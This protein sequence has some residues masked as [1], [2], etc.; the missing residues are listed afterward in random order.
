ML[1]SLTTQSA[2]FY[3]KN[4]LAHLY[5]NQNV[6]PVFRGWSIVS[7]H[8]EVMYF[9][10][11]DSLLAA[12]NARFLHIA[13]K[14]VEYLYRIVFLGQ[15]CAN[16][17]TFDFLSSIRRTFTHQ[18]QNHDPCPPFLRYDTDYWYRFSKWYDLLK[19]I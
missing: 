11:A 2:P 17:L 14:I 19:G 4:L 9:L 6:N 12:V 7:C 10:N 8:A 18:P 13:R 3:Y 16:L 15:N 1:A 5:P